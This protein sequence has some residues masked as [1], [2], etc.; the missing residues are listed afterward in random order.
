M[1]K[2][3]ADTYILNARW[4]N[5]FHFYFNREARRF[6]ISTSTARRNLA[7]ENLVKARDFSLR[8]KR[9]PSSAMLYAVHHASLA[10]KME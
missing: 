2:T 8:S 1:K 5:S 9:Q 10:L 4:G 7:K 6:V 3:G